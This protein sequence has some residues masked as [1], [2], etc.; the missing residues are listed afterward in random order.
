MTGG[1]RKPDQDRARLR[2]QLPVDL[3]HR[4]LAH[5]VYAGTPAGIA[6]LTA[7]KVD[8]DGSQS[9]PAQFMPSAS[10]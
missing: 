1:F 10:W 7:G 5:R 3:E 9:R 6:G 2:H 4:D 8:P